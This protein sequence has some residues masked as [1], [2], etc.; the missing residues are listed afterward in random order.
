MKVSF[1]ISSGSYVASS[2]GRSDSSS[3]SSEVSIASSSGGL[4]VVSSS[5]VDIQNSNG[6]RSMQ[7]PILTFLA[8]I[9][10][11]TFSGLKI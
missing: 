3:A 2:T 7:F 5:G 6:S 11:L 8:V 9:L 4:S 10:I 1:G